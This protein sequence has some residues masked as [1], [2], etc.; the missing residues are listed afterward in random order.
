LQ[1]TIPYTLQ[2]NGVVERK[3]RSLKEM[4]YYMLHAISLPQKLWDEVINCANYIQNRSPHIYVKDQ[5]PFR[6]WTNN[7]LEVTH[8]HVFSSRAW[9]QIPSEKRK[10]LDPQSNTCIFVGYPYGVKGYRFIDPSMD[11]LIIERSVQFEESIS[12]APQ[13]LHSDVFVL[14]PV[15]DDEF[16]H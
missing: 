1:H 6:A 13:E 3:N 11:Q 14:P 8:F 15:Q 16:G 10:A 9:A 5:T 2:Q 7:K 12:H 4:A